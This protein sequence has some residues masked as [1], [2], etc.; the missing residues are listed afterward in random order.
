MISV[1]H[2][3]VGGTGAEAVGKVGNT[4]HS[5]T[6]LVTAGPKS[7]RACAVLQQRSL[8]FGHLMLTEA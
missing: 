6:R 1:C 5:G 7:G 2:A 4:L 8:A 3:V